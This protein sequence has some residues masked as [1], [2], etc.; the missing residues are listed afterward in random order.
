MFWDELFVKEGCF[1]ARFKTSK[2]NK[3]MSISPYNFAKHAVGV[4]ASSF[5]HLNIGLVLLIFFVL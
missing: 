3:A 2:R 4:Q 5:R 1:E